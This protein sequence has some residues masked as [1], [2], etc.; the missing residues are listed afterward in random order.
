MSAVAVTRDGDT[1]GAEFDRLPTGGFKAWVAEICDDL[2]LDPD[3]SC[4]SD[5]EGF[6]GD[7]GR[8]VTDWPT[9]RDPPSTPA[10]NPGAGFHPRQ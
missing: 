7:D 1:E 10:P 5:E 6:I 2:G 4:W 9:R 3:W 8:P